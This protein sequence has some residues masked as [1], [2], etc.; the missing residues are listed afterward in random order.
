MNTIQPMPAPT[1]KPKHSGLGVT[2]FILSIFLG[3][4]G[5]ILG[6]IDLIVHKENKHGLSIA[7][8][9]IGGVIT[10]SFITNKLTT[11]TPADTSSTN[12]T[13]NNTSPKTDSSSKTNTSTP[14]KTVERIKIGDEFGNSTI[15]GAV[16][17]ANLDYK[18]YNDLWTTIDEGYKAV[19]IRIMLTI[20]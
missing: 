20:F 6:I 10:A 8:V 17:S 19:Y 7:A 14:T 1:P 3:P 15:K 5:L 18:Y 11:Q 16:I 13:Y 2:A 9:I 12:I 4:V